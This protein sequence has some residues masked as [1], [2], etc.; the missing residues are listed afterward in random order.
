MTSYPSY[1][2]DTPSRKHMW[3]NDSFYDILVMHQEFMT[4]E[5]KRAA[6]RQEQI[7]EEKVR[8]RIAK[9]RR[10]SSFDK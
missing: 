8:L 10:E 1:S 5:E 3:H 2:S 4:A 6:E 7:E 9:V